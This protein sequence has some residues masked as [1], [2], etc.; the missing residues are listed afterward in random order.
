[1]QISVCRFRSLAFP[2]EISGRFWV[3]AVDL[4]DD[5]PS[6]EQALQAPAPSL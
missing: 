4:K 2:T 6:K 1:V 3:D 5:T